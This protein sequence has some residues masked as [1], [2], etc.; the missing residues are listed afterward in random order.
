MSC[1]ANR[2]LPPTAVLFEIEPGLYS[3]LPAVERWAPS[4]LWSATMM[5]GFDGAVTPAITSGAALRV[6]FN[7]PK[8]LARAMWHI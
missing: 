3:I 5:S 2:A 6:V 4:I 8:D 1:N 7:D